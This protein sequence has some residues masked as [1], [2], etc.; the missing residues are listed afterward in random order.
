MF[1]ARNKASRWRTVGLASLATLRETKVGFGG[2]R[3]SHGSAAARER[4]PDGH[5]QE[6]G[7][8]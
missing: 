6:A 2:R 8:S 5:A 3:E 1:E 7:S 4:A